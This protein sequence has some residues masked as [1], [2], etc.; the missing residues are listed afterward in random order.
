[1][2]YTSHIG[3]YSHSAGSVPFSAYTDSFKVLG[4]AVHE[5]ASAVA[6]AVARAIEAARTKAAERATVQSLREVSDETLKDIGIHRSEI[7]YLAR[8][9]SENP[10]MDYRVFRQ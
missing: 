7:R 10:G 2:S 6:H 4:E 9:V 5:A 3:R 8:R 1:M